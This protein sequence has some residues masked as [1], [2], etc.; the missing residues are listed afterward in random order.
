MNRRRFLLTSLAGALAAPLTAEAQQ[1]GKLPTIGVLASSRLTESLQGQIRDGL[2]EH[3]YVE[4][5][6]IVIEW[7]AAEDRNDRAAA[8]ATELARLRV[9]VIV[10]HLTPVVQAAKKA[11]S[12]IPIVMA[13]V[14]DPV[15]SGFVRSLAHP[16]GNI[17]GTSIMAP[18]LVGK[19]LE[20]LKQVVPTASRVALLSNP[21]KAG[22]APQLQAAEMAARALGA[23]STLGGAK[24]RRDRPGLRGDDERACR[25]ASRFAG[26]GPR[27]P[28]RKDRRSHS[29]NR[30]PAVY[31]VRLHTEAGGLMSYGANSRDMLRRV[32]SYVDRILTGARPADLPI[33]QPSKFELVINLKTAKALGLTIPPS[34]L[35]RA[36]Q[37]IQ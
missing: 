32:A 19:Q 33:E 8:L 25:C 34:L 11:T 26:P 28:A 35:A 17:T 20:L 12:T 7:R 29:K 21:A 31:G 9:D 3:G 13:F 24:S 14:I 16:E 37:V 18:D 36:D 2:K 27:G 5:R 15:G 1:A 23:A 30:L 22:S 4:G 6:N 10:A